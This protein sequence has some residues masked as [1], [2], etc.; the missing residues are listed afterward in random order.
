[1]GEQDDQKQEVSQHHV[2]NMNKEKLNIAVKGDT[3]T[4]GFQKWYDEYRALDG[5]S[6]SGDNEILLAV[7]NDILDNQTFEE[8]VAKFTAHVKGGFCLQCQNLF[9]NWPDLQANVSEDVD[10]GQD[11]IVHKEG[12][13]HHVSLKRFRAH[14]L[15]ASTRQGCRFCAL[16]RQILIDTDMLEIYRKVEARVIQFDEDA[17]MALSIQN[18]GKFSITK[19]QLLWPNLPGKICTSCNSGTALSTKFLSGVVPIPGIILP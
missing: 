9:N 3:T 8:D 4:S 11:S 1:M 5:N 15:E 12:W 14:E 19:C 13:E 7:A 6:L 16:I 18:W 10:P 17:K 2:N